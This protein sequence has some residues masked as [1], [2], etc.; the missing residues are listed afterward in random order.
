MRLIAALLV[1]LACAAPAL[2]GRVA[3]VMGNGD[4]IYEKPLRNAAN[5]ARDMAERLRAMGFEVFEGIDLTR[6]QSLRL[7]QQFSRAMNVDDTAL[8][9]FAGHGIQL[10]SD[11][12]ILPVDAEP[13]TEIDLTKSAIRLQSILRSMESGADTR[14]VIL[15]A[16]RNNPFLRD[17][18]NRSTGESRGL[19]RMEAGVGSFIAFST[20]PGNVAADGAGRN[21][22]FTAA[23]LRHIST[24]GADIHAVMRAVRADVR[25]SSNGTQIPWENSALIDE[26]FLTAAP[27][28]A[29]STARV[30]AA[31]APAPRHMPR[32]QGFSETCIEGNYQGGDVRFC[33]SSELT[34]QGGNSYGP[35]NLFDGNPATAWV[36]G[37][38]GT[39][40]GQALSFDFAAP[41]TV[42]RL[43]LQ[44]G[45]TKSDRT[46]TRNARVRDL[47]V[48]GSTGIETRLRLADSQQWQ[49]FPLPGFANQQWI[50]LEIL[51]TY[52]GTHYADTAISGLGFD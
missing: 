15:D 36:E 35:G 41:R 38:A 11:N 43:H 14:I 39:G 7:V 20:E 24:P 1:C 23:L 50:R 30:P 37:V 8:F 19:M 17:R 26:V 27:A 3:L 25:D 2:A 45:Y 29:T 40:E 12:Y 52:P 16:C 33:A 6:D 49:S 5:D 32:P 9:Y 48:T 47:L 18:A 13:G 10:G 44:N 22:P 34:A 28:P 31:I 4:Y 46:F 21:S 51:S 42:L